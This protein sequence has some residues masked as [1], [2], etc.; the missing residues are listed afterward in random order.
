MGGNGMEAGDILVHRANEADPTL[1]QMLVRLQYPLVTGVI[2][3]FE[4]VTFEEREDV[5]TQQV[6]TASSFKKTDDL[7]FSGETYEVK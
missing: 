1:H 7:F 5:L 4:D 2:R 3:S 6:K